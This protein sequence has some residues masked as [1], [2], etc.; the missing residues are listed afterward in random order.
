MVRN[1]VQC[2]KLTGC[3]LADS[4]GVV[5]KSNTTLGRI[6]LLCNVS[7]HSNAPIVTDC[8]DVDKTIRMP[9]TVALG[10]S[11]F[12]FAWDRTGLLLLL[13][14]ILYVMYIVKQK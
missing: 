2:L 5:H 4:H 10:E 8:L 13:E 7:H 1:S 3:K 12:E 9:I 14:I 11:K 6:L